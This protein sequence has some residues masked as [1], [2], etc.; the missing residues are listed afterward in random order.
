LLI[1]S[2]D[3]DFTL[4]SGPPELRDVLHTQATRCLRALRPR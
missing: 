4:V 3:A 1:T 2:V